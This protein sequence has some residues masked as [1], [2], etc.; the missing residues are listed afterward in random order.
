M[1]YSYFS[2]WMCIEVH[3]TA[4]ICL[5]CRDSTTFSYFSSR[6]CIDGYWSPNH[7]DDLLN[8]SQYG[9]QHRDVWADSSRFV[10]KQPPHLDATSLPHEHLGP[11]SLPSKRHLTSTWALRAHHTT[12]QAPPHPGTTSAP[13]ERIGP[14]T[15][16][17]KR[18]LTRAPRHHYA[19]DQGP[20]HY[21]ASATSP[22]HVHIGLTTLPRKRH[23][24]RAPSHR[25]LTQGMH[26]SFKKWCIPRDSNPKPLASNKV[27]ITTRIR[28]QLWLWLTFN[29]FWCLL[30]WRV[31][32]SELPYSHP[33]YV[34]CLRCSSPWNF[35]L[36][37]EE[38]TWLYDDTSVRIL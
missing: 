18:H 28:P 25:Q 22:P 15:L 14:T 34:L 4:T 12:T 5:I 38:K 36:L 19:S 30:S 26:S 9:P 21:H 10:K 35:E 31:K 1:T 3:Y 16:P 27:L 33:P 23:L 32:R 8:S 13:R 24:T 20:P 11:T 7:H 6:M 17:R 29:W 37:G 2:S